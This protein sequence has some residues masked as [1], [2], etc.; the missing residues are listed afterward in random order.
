MLSHANLLLLV[1]V[2]GFSAVRKEDQRGDE[3]GNVRRSPA[4]CVIPALLGGET[5]VVWRA[6]D[7]VVPNRDVVE[8]RTIEQRVATDGVERR[9]DEPDRS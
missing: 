2:D 1:H 4:A 8:V 7:Y 3:E 9:V 6:V 5:D